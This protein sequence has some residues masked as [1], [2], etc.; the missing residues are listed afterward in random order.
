MVLAGKSV[1]YISYNGMLDWLGQ[2]QVI[3]YLKQLRGTG[4]RFTLL[5]FERPDAYTREGA[6]ACEK[7]KRELSDSGI[8]WHWLPYH[9]TPSL[10]ATSYDVLAGI[11]YGSRLVRD[12]RIEMVHA[13]SHVPATMALALKRRFGVKIIFDI[14]GLMADEYVDAGHWR[15]GSIAYRITKHYEG[16]ALAQADGVV[17]L[18]ERI[19]PIINQ[20]KELRDRAV[21]H[22]VIPSR[23][24]GVSWELK[25]GSWL[26]IAGLL[27]VGI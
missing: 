12:K 4:V 11:R 5:S 16:R 15:K 1:L 2:S 23:S 19:W 8:E 24:E 26:S 6:D 14:R 10:L 20:W 27:T 21:V 22:E 18:T 17:T 3:P 9:K 13:R 25:T 7:L